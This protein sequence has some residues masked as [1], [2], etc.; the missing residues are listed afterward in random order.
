M[1]VILKIHRD[2]EYW[3]NP[4][5]FDPDRFLPE[6]IKDCHASSYIPFSD[7]PRN[8]IGIKYGIMSMKVILATLIR[9]FIFKVNK[10][11]EIDKIKLSFDVVISPVEPFKV[12]IEKRRF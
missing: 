1:I 7:G 6:R 11:I 10:S 2:K 8:C 12:K 4:L 5:V 3:S 9:T